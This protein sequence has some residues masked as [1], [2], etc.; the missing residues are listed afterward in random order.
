LNRPPGRRIGRFM[1][2][3]LLPFDMVKPQST[4][5][6]FRPR[7]RRPHKS[8]T[9]SLPSRAERLPIGYLSEGKHLAIT[10]VSRARCH[11]SGGLLRRP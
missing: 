10:G 11:Q 2:E 7:G 1:F 3:W 9:E 6:S 4:A 8:N 5:V